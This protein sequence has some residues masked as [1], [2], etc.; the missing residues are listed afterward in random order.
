MKQFNALETKNEI[1]HWLKERM[2]E[3]VAVIGISGGKDSSVVAALCVEALGRE[4]VIGILMPNGEQS[5]I[6]FSHDL[7][8]H[9][10][11]AHKVINIAP[12]VDAFTTSLVGGGELT[13]DAKTNLPARVRM[14]TLYGF[15][16]HIS[17][18]IGGAWV[19][20]TSNLSEDV[21][22]FAT[23]YGDSAGA[24]SPLGMLTTD[25]VREVGRVLGLPEHLIEKTPTD[26]LTGKTDEESF[27]FSYDVLNKYIREGIC[28][29][30]ETRRKIEKMYLASRFKF[31][32]IPM[33][34]PN[35]EIKFG[36]A[37]GLYY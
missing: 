31:Y 22:G 5:D 23:L 13:S 25:E 32:G 7:V 20:N 27:G 29:D 19:M 21:V 33:F 30:E 10:N 8:K 34:N 3:R 36:N 2:E 4:K 9:L 6:S 28:E 11:I 17:R 12:M 24:M 14:T 1:V 18:A 35:V 26:G 16:Q 15:A 37:D